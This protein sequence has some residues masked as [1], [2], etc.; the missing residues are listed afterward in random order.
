MLI[1]TKI[2]ALSLSAVAIVCACVG[3]GMATL[4]Q[5]GDR[6]EALQTAHEHAFRAERVNRLVTAVVM[7]SRGIYAAADTKAAAKFGEGLEQSLV[8]METIL[9]GWRAETLPPEE[10]AQFDLVDGK[11]GEFAKFRREIA[12]AG[13]DVSPAEAGK[14][15]NNETNRANRK[16]FQAEIDKMVALAER[17]LDGIEADLAAFERRT[18]TTFLA[19]AV[20]AALAMLA[21]AYWI[22]V[23]SIS[24]PLGRIAATVSAIADGAYDTAVPRT[25]ANDEI[26]VLWRAT[27]ALRDKAA[28]TDELKR[29][30][31]DRDAEAAAAFAAERGRIAD[32][33][34]ARM[35][36]L[37]AEFVGASKSVA[38]AAQRLRDGSDATTAQVG[39]AATAAEEAAANVGVVAAS[40][41]ELAASVREINTQVTRSAQISVAAVEQ[42]GDAEAE[43]KKL[44]SAA[45]EI[46]DVVNLISA[47][48][49]QTNLL[50]LNATI[51]AA[52]AGEAG[53]GF[54][55]VASEVKNLAG[56]T[57][58][59]TDE[60]ARKIAEIQGAT[61]SAVGA[62]G[63]I[64]G[65]I[66]EVRELTNAIAGAVEQQGAAT[67]EIADNTHR[68]ANGTHGASRNL[69]G[70]GRV[71]AETGAAAGEL[72]GLSDALEGRAADIEH[73]V[74]TFV[75]SLR[76]A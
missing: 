59:A 56:Q 33:F 35:G 7:D 51:E 32:A 42:A 37:A 10:R 43:I 41:E 60:I 12:A 53:R 74:R 23:R 17:D 40:T 34:Q 68:A 58:K 63:T 61:G 65:T 46:G 3:L 47:I 67:A 21:A 5:Y 2:V 49:A 31:A 45:T 4:A 73:E 54:A 27:A 55:V 38:A 72:M 64:V 57:G 76:A 75:Q 15:G 50:A 20:G 16:A 69:D 26:G 1:R 28:E 8:D 19:V 71:A 44:A 25:T 66:G 70:L 14:L 36:K 39:T 30:Q 48:A 6:V 22:G 18:E 52:R 13:R 24:R 29:R 9:S 62:I 11:A